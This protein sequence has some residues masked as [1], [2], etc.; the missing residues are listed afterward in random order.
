MDGSRKGATGCIGFLRL[1][2]AGNTQMGRG[3]RTIGRQNQRPS[4]L[5]SLPS[6]KNLA[7]YKLPWFLSLF[8]I[9][10]VFLPTCLYEKTER[11]RMTSADVTAHMA[12]QADLNSRLPKGSNVKLDM[13]FNGNGVLE[14]VY[15]PLG[16]K[17][18]TP[19]HDTPLY[20][21]LG[22]AC[23]GKTY[24]ACPA[25]AP[26][27]CRNCTKDWRKPLGGFGTGTTVG[28]HAQWDAAQFLAG[29]DVY[30]LVST[31]DAAKDAFY[32]TSHMFS[33]QVGVPAQGNAQVVVR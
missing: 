11:Y 15:S 32:W 25:G 21:S 12:W 23:F 22:C 3:D 14:K 16:A 2:A 4:P 19:C 27:F 7:P 29:Y 33:H 28:P 8:Q 6:T 13:V 5:A 1:V 18:L 24:A 10:D 9:D 20:K 30:K 31:T 26:P 17:D